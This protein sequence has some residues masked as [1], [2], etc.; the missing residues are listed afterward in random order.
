MMKVFKSS[1]SKDGV[2]VTMKDNIPKNVIRGKK[3]ISL[4]GV[5]NVVKV[6]SSRTVI[7]QGGAGLPVADEHF[8]LVP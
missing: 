2:A 8:M 5:W 6:E 4:A 1:S 3:L 7:L